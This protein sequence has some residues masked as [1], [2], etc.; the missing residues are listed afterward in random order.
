MV[1]VPGVGGRLL[2]G[3]THDERPV[4]LP[5]AR[6]PLDA[7][8]GRDQPGAGR[9]P[10][11]VDDRHGEPVATVEGCAGGVEADRVELVGRDRAAVEADRLV[12]AVALE[13]HL[14]AHEPGAGA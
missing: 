3:V 12:D 14:H 1:T 7:Q 9:K 10:A 5:P 11:E 2:V 4:V 13:P 6:R 8:R